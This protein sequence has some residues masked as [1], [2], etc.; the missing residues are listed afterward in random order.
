M[1]ER[2]YSL[3]EVAAEHLPAHWKNPQRWLIER[4]NRRELRGV[5]FGRTWRMR[6]RDVQYLLDRYANDGKVNSQPKP[7]AV[8]ATCIADGLSAR[9]RRRIQAAS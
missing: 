5:R 7:A 2:T 9:S 4:L 3:A 6:E 1:T 8:E